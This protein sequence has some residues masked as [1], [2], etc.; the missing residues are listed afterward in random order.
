MRLFPNT[1][2]WPP[3]YRFA[4]LL[5]WAGAFIASG[6]AIAQGIWGADKLTFGILIVVAIYCIAMAILMPRWALNAREESARRAQARKAR[7]ELKRR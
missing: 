6:A 5:M 1:S 3:N 2:E 4:Y 7:E